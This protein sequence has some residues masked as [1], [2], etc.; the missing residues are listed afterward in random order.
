MPR[1]CPF[2]PPPEYERL[3]EKGPLARVSFL[4]G[5]PV[6]VVTRQD[7]ARQV[8]TDLRFSTD[9]NTPGHPLAAFAGSEEEQAGQFLDVDPPE[10]DRYRRMVIRD[11][12]VKRVREMRPVIQNVV[13]ELVDD[14]LRGDHADLVASFG[15]PLASLVICQ[16]LGVPYEDRDYFHNC[17]RRIAEASGVGA[18]KETAAARTELIDYLGK[19]VTSASRRPGEDVLSRLVTT[20]LANGELSH[21]ELVGIAFLLLVAGHQTTANML[22]LGVFTLLQYTAQLAELRAAPKLWPNAVEELLRFHSMVDWV[23]FDRVATEDVDIGGQLIRAGEGVFVLGASANRDGRVYDQPDEFDI[24]RGSHHHLAFGFGFHQCLGQHLA[25]A[26]LEI[27]LRTLF[28]RI[29][30]MHITAEPDELSFKYANRTFGL[31]HL[32]VAW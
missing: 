5:R 14:L 23:A 21:E 18:E 31:Y 25:R 3:R 7:E 28:E 6:W 8:L 10:H 20:Q 12:S 24:H 2:S 17:T 16:V 15:L 13:D 22:P 4:D 19:L 30:S 26:E 27:G 11:F 9:P 32:P 29:P 1:R